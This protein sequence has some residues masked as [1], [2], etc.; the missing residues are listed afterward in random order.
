LAT[1]QHIL[2]A[3][4]LGRLEKVSGKSSAEQAEERYRKRR[5]E[6]ALELF[7]YAVAWWAMLA[8]CRVGG[9]GV[10]RRLVSSL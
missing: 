10:S 2:R 1:G 3:T 5:T 4:A 7:G 8:V 9:M 6:L